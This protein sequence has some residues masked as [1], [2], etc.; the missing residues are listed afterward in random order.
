[1][2]PGTVIDQRFVIDRLAGEGGMGTVYRALDRANGD[3][4][5]ALKVLQRIVQS[6]VERFRREADTLR[7]VSHPAVLRYVCDG[8]HGPDAFLVTE[9]LDGEDLQERLAREGMTLAETISLA[10]R[11]ASALD[12]VHEHGLVHR[13]LKPSNLFLVDRQPEKLKLLDFGLARMGHTASNITQ[14]GVLM[15]TPG[16]MAPEQARGDATLDGR[17]DLFALGCVL[18]KCLT[19]EAPFHGTHVVA[20]LARILIEDPP[21]P[22][23]IRGDIPSALDAL[24][25]QLLAKE[26]ARRP[27]N[28]RA[29]LAPVSYTHLTL[30][31]ILRV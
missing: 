31:T 9:W 15:G 13:D 16:Y 23:T 5:V 6:D 4:P 10:R 25:M 24:V 29:V 18:Y 12:A 21:A 30:P 14:T 11:V 27:A 2:K 3:A 28:A 22:S 1:M 7:F 20:T 17:A 19:G 26:P 8:A